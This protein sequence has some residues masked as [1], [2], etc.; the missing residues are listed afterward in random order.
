MERITFIT[1]NGKRILLEDFTWL[2]PGGEFYQ[3]LAAAKRMIH[4]EPEQSVLA[5]FDATGATFDQEVVNAVKDFTI[6][7]KPYVKAAAV[8]G[9]TGLL[10]IALLAVKTFSGRDFRTFDTREEALEWL[11]AQ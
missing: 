3:T 10:K 11:V 6:S 9:I 1:R 7:N 2:K 4:A 5:L 8:V